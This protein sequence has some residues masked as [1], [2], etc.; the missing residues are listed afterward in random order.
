[1]KEMKKHYS[2]FIARHLRALSVRGFVSSPM[3]WRA[4]PKMLSHATTKMQHHAT[5]HVQG[6]IL[7]SY[8]KHGR[9][10]DCSWQDNRFPKRATSRFTGTNAP[11]RKKW[12]E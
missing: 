5:L 3:G 7:S 8:K 6:S 1:M 2:L 4:M 11:Q 12:R 9:E 10:A